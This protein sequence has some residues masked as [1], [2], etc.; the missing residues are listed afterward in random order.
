MGLAIFTL[1]VGVLH[2]Q[3]SGA[4]EIGNAQLLSKHE[5]NTVV[6]CD[7]N[8]FPALF[9]LNFNAVKAGAVQFKGL[10]F[11]EVMIACMCI[12][13]TAAGLQMTSSGKE[14]LAARWFVLASALNQIVAAATVVA[15]LARIRYNYLFSSNNCA[16]INWWGRIDSCTG[17]SASMWL[18]IA[19][20]WCILYHGL[21]LDWRHSQ[22]FH[23]MEKDWRSLANGDQETDKQK[24]GFDQTDYQYMRLRATV[25]SKWLELLPSILVGMAG[26]ETLVRRIPIDSLITDWGQSAALVLAIAGGIHWSYVIYQVFLELLDPDDRKLRSVNYPRYNRDPY[27]KEADLNARLVAAAK[28][29]DIKVVRHLLRRKADVNTIDDDKKTSLLYAIGLDNLDLVIEL[30]SPKHRANPTLTGVTPAVSFAAEKGSIKVL[31]Y[32]IPEAA[33]EKSSS[34]QPTQRIAQLFAKNI[35]MVFRSRKRQ[36]V[37]PHQPDL[38]GRSPLWLAAVNEQKDAIKHIGAVWSDDTIYE[39]FSVLDKST[40]HNLLWELAYT[41]KHQILR[42]PFLSIFPQD[43]RLQTLREAV[44]KCSTSQGSVEVIATLLKLGFGSLEIGN[45]GATTLH[46]LCRDGFAESDDFATIVDA[47]IVSGQ[48]VDVFDGMHR[49]P[50]HVAWSRKDARRNIYGAKLCNSGA[51][52]FAKTSTGEHRSQW[53]SK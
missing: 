24:S 47:H 27:P 19:V 50:L 25:F 10:T 9:Y 28:I 46:Q 35:T 32:F 29:G 49:T 36:Q 8:V 45:E 42:D 26:V 41:Q 38:D 18:Y 43:I 4:K 31:K 13:L 37:N 15:M 53:Q 39:A 5:P 52:P 1:L 21:W 16:V 2:N 44:S 3:D 11:P 17:P 12:D 14:T 51:N 48:L 30:M 40:K 6:D 33:A 34:L 22:N 7:S 20:R 23:V